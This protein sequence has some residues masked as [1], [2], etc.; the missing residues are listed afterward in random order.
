MTESLISSL[1]Y[2][3]PEVALFFA[4]LLLLVV[5]AFRKT[6]ALRI[7]HFGAVLTMA[8]ALYLALMYRGDGVI[9]LFNDLFVN[10]AFVHFSQALILISAILSLIISRHWLK[11][12]AAYFEYP[13]L[14]LI[15]TLGMML[16]VS[17]NDLIS[18]YIAI[19]LTS[20]PLY[21][22]ASIRR[23]NMLSSEAGLKYFTLGSLAS[24]MLLFGSSLI[25]GFSGT[26]SF[27]TLQLLFATNSTFSPGII[28][29]MVMLI[30]ALCFKVSA[31]PFHMWTPDVYQGAPTPVTAFFATAPKVAGVV[32]FVRLLGDHLASLIMQW[33]DIMILIAIL[34]MLIGAFGALLQTNIK[35]MLAYSSIGHV[36]FLMAG[37]ASGN[38]AGAQAI[39]IYLALYIFMTLGIFACLL[40]LKKDGRYI[41][42]IK[43]LAG[44]SRHKPLLALSITLLLFSMAGIPPLA[45]FFAK[46][47]IL[48]AA[49]EAGLYPLAVIGVLASVI[50]AFYYIMIVK[51]MYFDDPIY[52]F[53]QTLSL[54]SVRCVLILSVAIT[55]LF[56]IAPSW[57]VHSAGR[58]AAALLG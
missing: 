17:A 51:V 4:A 40:I 36:G 20:L 47:Y 46:M 26:T 3:I 19:E 7:V 8:A 5:G 53:S 1:I 49:I 32:I 14:V 13:I 22:L 50:S 44:L 33:Q 30:V 48:L 2:S 41:E 37:L 34:T 11:E 54:A 6:E 15:A 18:L 43:H 23:D 55:L 24:G 39:L 42:S 52:D 12:Y 35:R 38:I 25:Y 27:E 16:L 29:G 21:I 10:H 9:H 31:A 28:V 45:G 58:A 57:L 56:F